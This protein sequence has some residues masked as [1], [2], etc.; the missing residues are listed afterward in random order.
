MLPVV[1]M[2][3]RTVDG[4]LA[5]RENAYAGSGVSDRI[6]ASAGNTDRAGPRKSSSAA[7]MQIAAFGL[8]GRSSARRRPMAAPAEW[9]T[10]DVRRQAL[11]GEQG[12]DVR[13]HVGE[14]AAAG[15]R[16]G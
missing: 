7:L 16:G 3:L 5:A 15:R 8:A 9:P 13:A 12:R 14:A 1:A 2:A 10:I 6:W 4:S 11:C